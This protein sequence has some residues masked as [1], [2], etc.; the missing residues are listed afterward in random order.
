MN[1]ICVNCKIVVASQKRPAR[2]VNC[3][4]TTFEQ[5]KAEPTPAPQA[6]K[7]MNIK[8]K[9]TPGKWYWVAGNSIWD[10][11]NHL[12]ATTVLYKANSTDES[13][14]SLN[15]KAIAAV[16][17]MLDIIER[18]AN[19]FTDTAKSKDHFSKIAQDAVQLLK[20]LNQ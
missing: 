4:H 11:T 13:I 1:W 6:V 2:C 3:N 19:H 7:I 8:D 12:V 14:S 16:P 15:A 9:I 20:Q 17:E 5:T 10:N 18:L